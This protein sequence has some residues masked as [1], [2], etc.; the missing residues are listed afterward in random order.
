MY[1]GVVKAGQGELEEAIALFTRALQLDSS[2]Q[3]AR[4]HLTQAQ[5]LLNNYI[6]NTTT[7]K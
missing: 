3:A 6:T 5:Q 1:A 2:H 4:K 7:H